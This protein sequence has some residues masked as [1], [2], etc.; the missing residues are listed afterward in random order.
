MVGVVLE[1]TIDRHRGLEVLHP[2]YGVAVRAAYSEQ[3]GYRA[4]FESM[5]TPEALRLDLTRHLLAAL[6]GLDAKGPLLEEGNRANGMA[7]RSDGPFMLTLVPDFRQ[8]EV[9]TLGKTG[10]G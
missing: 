5:S 10:F 2:G 9:D 7:T 4:A 6:P 8:Q 3:A 1:V